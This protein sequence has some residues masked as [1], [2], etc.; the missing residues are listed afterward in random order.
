MTSHTY[1]CRHISAKAS[2][3]HITVLSLHFT[4]QGILILLKSQLSAL[5]TDLLECEKKFWLESKTY[6][7][8]MI[9][10]HQF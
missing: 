9:L 8:T 1:K 10:Y 5:K 3:S 4:I 6:F 7:S 2:Q